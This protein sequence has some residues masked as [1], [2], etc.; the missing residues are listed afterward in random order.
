M[1]ALVPLVAVIALPL[2]GVA[3]AGHRATTA[4]NG[5]I[6]F[7]SAR[8]GGYDIYAMNP[9]ASDQRRLTTAPQTD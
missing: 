5:K 9:D 6:A 3:G 8:E 4:F 2:A 1:R 7:S